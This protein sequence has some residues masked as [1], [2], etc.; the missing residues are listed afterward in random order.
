MDLN[1][2]GERKCFHCQK[3]FAS[4]MD[5][6]LHEECS[7]LNKSISCSQCCELTF[8]D[9]NDAFDH[10]TKNHDFPEFDFFR[11]PTEEY[12]CL[13]CSLIFYDEISYWVHYYRRHPRYS[14]ENHC[15][16]IIFHV[17]FLVADI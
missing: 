6:I 2:P 15:S 1:I 17:F 11:E 10:V 9:E 12:Q 13:N 7:H 8:S 14:N 5:R 16:V 3:S 4:V